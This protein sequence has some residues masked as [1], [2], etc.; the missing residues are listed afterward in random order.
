[1]SKAIETDL[2][3]RTAV[4]T[5]ASTVI[6]KEIARA[7]AALG[8]HVVLAVRDDRRGE[9]ARDVIGTAPGLF[10]RTSVMRVDLASQTSIRSFVSVF[11]RA[12]PSLDILVNNAGCWYT[13]KRT[14]S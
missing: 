9:A 6:G 3:N 4:V 7:L 14:S 8:A 12:Y 2:S 11:E 5:G 10:D 13:E 1:M